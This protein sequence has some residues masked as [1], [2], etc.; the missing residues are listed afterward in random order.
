MGRKPGSG[1]GVGADE[2]LHLVRI[3]HAM[4]VEGR[5]EASLSRGSD[6]YELSLPY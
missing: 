4:H 2:R 3:V 5:P 6:V 1:S